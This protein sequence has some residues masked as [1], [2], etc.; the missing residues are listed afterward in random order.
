MNKK[1]V[2]LAFVMLISLTLVACGGNETKKRDHLV[3]SVWGDSVDLAN[4]EKIAKAYEEQGGMHVEVIPATGDYYDSLNIS[5]A[6]KNNAPDLFFTESGEFIANLA[7]SKI[8]NLQPYIDSGALDVATQ[9]NPNGE[10]ELWDVN[11]AYRYDGENIGSGDY[12]AII[13]VLE[14]SSLSS[15]QPCPIER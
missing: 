9:A 6:S 14:S 10:I 2:T 8:M 5:F 7:S 13:K 15:E 11:D 12:Y 4:Y 3:F 1:L